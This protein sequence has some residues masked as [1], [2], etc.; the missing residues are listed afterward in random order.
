MEKLTYNGVTA[1]I[2]QDTRRAKN[3]LWFPV[4][5]RISYLRKQFYF[6]SGIDLTEE[7]WQMLPTTKKRDLLE[8][9]ELI[10]AGFYLVWDHAKELLKAGSF[11]IDALSKRLSRGSKNSLLTAFDAK[12]H[13]L[14]RAGQIGTAITYQCAMNSISKF[15]KRDLKLSDITVE[16]LKRYDAH[17][18][19]EEK[20]V[21][22][23]KI[24]M[25][26]IR[27][28]LNDARREG[29]ITETAYPFGRETDNKYEIRAGIGRKLALSLAQIKAVLDYPLYT[30]TEQRSRD[31]WFFSYLCNG[32][33][34]NDMLKLKYRNIAGGEIHFRRQKTQR[35]SRMQKEIIATM[36]PE[37]EAIINRW[38]NKPRRPESYIF[39]F[40]TD[41][42]DPVTQKKTIQN[43]VRLVN[44]K[45][46]QI[47]DALEF[48][49]IST[50]TARHSYATVLKRSGS[51][52]SFIS[53]SLG[54]SDLRTTE[55]Y[56]SSFETEERAK[57]ASKLTQF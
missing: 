53:E 41:K 9:K 14:N 2:I 38:G 11:S 7:E 16:W 29:I 24:Y 54:H 55:A 6:P 51:N 17:L 49:T 18:Q 36:L 35:T 48:D 44:K 12:I 25:G 26:C 21:T 52:I 20:A 31:L 22:T 37:M 4:K 43:A 32:I 46:K 33:N 3:E 50:Y 5:Y 39:P 23:V 19:E 42:M 10:Q 45:M 30:E 15:I 28:I 8:Q 27:A 40:L 1:T 57:N 47:S 13:E 34:F 56:L